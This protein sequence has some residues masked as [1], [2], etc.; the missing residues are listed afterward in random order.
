MSGF[1]DQYGHTTLH[2]LGLLATIIL[3]AGLVLFPRK[4]ALIPMI[5]MACFVSSAQRI[6][7][8]GIDLDLI[9]LLL[10]FGILRVFIR[11]EYR[12]VQINKLDRLMV[13]WS[14]SDV[15]VFS[16]AWGSWDAVINRAGWLVDGV[17]L[18][19]LFR[20]LIQTWEDIE[21]CIFS[22]MLISVPC[23][24]AFLLEYTTGHNV[25]AI[26]GGVRADTWIREGR[27]RCQGAF[28]HPIIA[29]CF[30]AAVLPWV[31]SR[32]RTGKSLFTMLCLSCSLCIVFLTGSSTPLAAVI[33][34]GIGLAFFP[35]R[36]H[37]KSI[38]WL[39]FCSLLFL[40][41]IMKKPVWHLISRIDFVGGSTG[42]HR[43][44]IIDTMI[45]NVSEWW[46]LGNTNAMSWGVWEMRDIT[47]H[48]IQI[49]LDG[50]LVTLVLFILLISTGFG[51]VGR[52]WRQIDA[53]D[54]KQLLA[55]SLGVSLFV[56]VCNF[57]AVSYFGSIS[58]VWS[59]NLAM[60]GTLPA[61]TMLCSESNNSSTCSDSNAGIIAGAQRS[62]NIKRFGLC[63]D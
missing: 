2:P 8:L 47:N 57:F 39:L 13:Y 31:F 55:W 11:R 4:F 32:F 48:Y 28:A 26:F 40:H 19:F 34:A 62:Q 42:W 12:A 58:I 20:C 6:V 14:L 17:G 44:R 51:I 10:M 3:G 45:Q 33:F 25:F 53:G 22:F 59:L 63:N 54:D 49:A 5:T 9:R 7:I 23:F 1:G 56:H 24:I 15:A 18:Y 46:L 38:R 50:G 43:Y 21:Y 36:H 30:W 60:I 37:M 29:G 27:L 35:I 61:L 52:A 16:L 41:F